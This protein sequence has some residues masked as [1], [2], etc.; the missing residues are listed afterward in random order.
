MELT[1]IGRCGGFPLPGEA[2]S[3]YLLRCAGKNIL[4][5]CGSAVASGLFRFLPIESLDMLLLSHLH[6]DH[7]ADLGVLKYAI[8][9]SRRFGIT[10]PDLPVYLPAGPSGLRPDAD[11]V[12]D[13]HTI[14]PD[15][16]IDLPGIAIRFVPG[17]HPVESYGIRVVC[18]GKTFAYTGDT[19]MCDNVADMVR[20]ADL[21]VMDAGSLER[22]RSAD[23]VHMT[24]RECAEAAEQGRVIRP[25]LSHIV[26]LIDTG[27]TLRE[28]SAICRR[29][30]IACPLGVYT[31][32]GA[33]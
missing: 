2:T 23:M 26:P 21:A 10:I 30:E 6:H 32:G 29:A 8:G 31:I 3:G 20:D 7:Q 4:I 5:D 1:I 27:E 13:L 17:A 16:R 33:I 15:T 19:R 28:A 9:M 24:A 12:L 14:G 25:I 11:G 22:L 18:D